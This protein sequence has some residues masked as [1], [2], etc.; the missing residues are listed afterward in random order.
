MIAWPGK[1]RYGPIGVDIGS[2][3][4]K[5]VQLDGQRSNL[6]DAARWELPAADDPAA[7]ER[8]DAIVA[9]LVEARS[10][11]DFR[12]REAVFCVAGR[13]LFVQNIRVPPASGDDLQKIV[14]FEAASR[15]PFSAE[16]ADIRYIDAADVR[17]GDTVR[18]EII[19]LACRH[20]AVERTISLAE[21][22]GLIPV[23][24]DAE[25]SAILRS[26]TKQARRDGDQEARVLLLNIGASSSTVVIARGGDAMFVKYLDVGGRQLDE[27]VARHLKLDAAGATSLRRHNGD[28]RT[29]Q[30]DPEVMRSF[31]EACRP[32]MEQLAGELAS[33]MRYYSVAFRGQPLSQ[34]VVSGGEASQTIVDWL[35]ERLDLPCELGN[36]VRTFANALPGG[37]STQWDVATGLALREIK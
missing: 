13:D 21:R 22:A 33:C 3:V 23:A 34:V 18:R 1:S 26:Y 7:E 20:A 25:P 16:Q 12:G 6:R 2:R 36:P 28:R 10:G 24:I 27:A 9:G 5:L 11:R 30:L 32:V 8:D 35:T 4:L 37:R 19:L 31:A 14:H 15:L 17:Q 29:D